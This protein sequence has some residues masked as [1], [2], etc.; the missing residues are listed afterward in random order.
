MD[1][2][3]KKMLGY[4]ALGVGALVVVNKLKGSPKPQPLPPG[5][6][7]SYNSNPNL[8]AVRPGTNT[9]ALLQA[10]P[11]NVGDNYENIIYPAM[12]AANPN[13]GNPG[14]TLTDSEAQTYLNNYL[15]IQQGTK[16]WFGG[17]H[18]KAAKSHWQTNGVPEKRTFMPLNPPSVIPYTGPPVSGGGGN[19]LSSALGVVTTV[20]G[21]LV[22]TE[23]PDPAITDRDL[24]VIVNS[25]YIIKEILP[26][27]YQTPDMQLAVNIDKKVSELLNKHLN[28]I[29]TV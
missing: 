16:Y 1:N 9:A 17:D 4:A 13:I 24:E 5:S 6:T 21:V 15:D 23:R 14:Y 8:P 2:G 3:T 11:P 28:Q 7:T 19:F 26:F 27:Y 12:L 22:G 25:A 10:L 20:L 18:L 29:V